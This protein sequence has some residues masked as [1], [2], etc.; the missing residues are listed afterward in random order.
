MWK[1]I[2]PIGRNIK[3]IYAYNTIMFKY[4]YENRQRKPEHFI[5]YDITPTLLEAKPHNNGT[6]NEVSS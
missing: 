1:G 5:G 2:P 6:H 4:L 3:L